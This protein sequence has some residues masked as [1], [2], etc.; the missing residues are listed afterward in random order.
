MTKTT[1]RS[2]GRRKTASPYAFGLVLSGGGTFGAWEAG[3]LQAL[4]SVWALK[5][6]NE[7][8]PIRIVAGT[9]AGALTAPFALGTQAHVRSIVNWWTSVEQKQI[10]TP[11][12][13]L[14]LPTVAFIALCD[15][16][17]DFGDP[18][19]KPCSLPIEYRRLLNG[20]LRDAYKHSNRADPLLYGNYKTALSGLKTL[21]L[22][23]DS[24]PDK[25]L[26]IATTDF[27]GGQGDVV[28]NSP[29][30][31]ASKKTVYESRLFRGIF[32]SAITPLMGY[33]V[34]LSQGD[35]SG[36]KTP[37][38]DGGVYS[39]APFNVLF[40]L[41]STA[42]AIP[43]THVIVISAYP[44]FPGP[45][46]PGTPKFPGRPNFEKIGLRF[47]T[48]VSEASAT[49]DTLLARAALGLRALGQSEKSV[50]DLTGLTIPSPPPV[51]IEAAPKNKL[52]WD[53]AT[54]NRL[55]MKRLAALGYRE[56]RK[57]FMNL[58]P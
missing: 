8:P 43:L 15:G 29:G 31:T 12:L 1:S 11:N 58:L 23:R 32:A 36:P 44:F 49:K 22:C 7:E 54:V 41:A 47:D 9:S 52:G 2:V 16:L 46:A 26:G 21:E 4:W 37:H 13:G 53:N 57:I 48:L 10:S 38:F 42:P 30:D 19:A 45:P 39:E 56:A 51:L 27:G 18:E 55:Q 17:A 25:R 50:R 34:L 6:N 3:A 40:A 20:P 14:L 35:A 28:T 5:H 24:W 33:P